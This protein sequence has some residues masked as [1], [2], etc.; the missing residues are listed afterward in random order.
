MKPRNVV[1]MFIIGWLLA[2]T[3]AHCQTMQEQKT[4]YD[5]AN[6]VAAKGMVVSNHYDA[7][8]KTCWVKEFETNQSHH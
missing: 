4:C 6:K 3:A 5:Q 8:T 2:A 7:R 1:V